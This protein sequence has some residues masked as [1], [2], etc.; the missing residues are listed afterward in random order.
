MMTNGKEGFV[1]DDPADVDRLTS[2]MRELL[3]PKRREEM[4][5]AGRAMTLDHT[6]DHQTTEFCQLYEDVLA[7]KR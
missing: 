2:C 6:F 7:A 3:D 5:A 4:G 1:V